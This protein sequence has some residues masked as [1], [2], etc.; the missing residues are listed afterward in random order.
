MP[1]RVNIAAFGGD[2]DNFNFPRYS[3]DMTFL[4]VYENGKPL[5]N[6]HWFSWADEGAKDG[7]M[8]FITGHPGRTSRLEPISVLEYLRD[9]QL[10]KSLTRLS[11]MRGLLHQF[12]KKDKE[13]KRISKSKLNGVEKRL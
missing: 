9:H 13:S 2:P 5:D 8:T 7:D 10:V 11:E 1:R 3:M 6:K 4:R 12:A